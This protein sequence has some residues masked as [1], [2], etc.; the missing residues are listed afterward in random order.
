MILQIHVT[1]GIDNIIRVYD[2]QG[3]LLRRVRTQF[4]T[5]MDLSALSKGNYKLAISNT[6]CRFTK[7]LVLP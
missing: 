5:A 6:I 4:D 7:N 1:K 3:V 2:K